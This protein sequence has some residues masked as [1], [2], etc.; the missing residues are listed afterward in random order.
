MGTESKV[1]YRE[2][3]KGLS[4]YSGQE[5]DLDFPYQSVFMD[6]LV[7]KHREKKY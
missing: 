7:L 3:M 4:F 6:G 5:D 2:E 1:V